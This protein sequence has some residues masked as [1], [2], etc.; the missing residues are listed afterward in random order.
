MCIRQRSKGTTS[1]PCERVRERERES[2]WQA[3]YSQATMP[4]SGV[5]SGEYGK[6]APEQASS[7]SIISAHRDGDRFSTQKKNRKVQTEDVRHPN[8]SV[9]CQ[10]LLLLGLCSRFPR[11][12]LRVYP[13]RIAASSNVQLF[14]LISGLRC[15]QGSMA[16]SKMGMDVLKTAG[17]N[18]GTPGRNGMEWSG[19]EC[20]FVCSV[21]CGCN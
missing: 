1:L 17:T 6:K 9:F 12:C 7:G 2:V 15:V 3:A 14:T 16:E 13:S 18:L 4:E 11:R 5:C 8:C 10:V 19:A 21:V 20:V